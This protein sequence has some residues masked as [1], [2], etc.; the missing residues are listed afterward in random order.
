MSGAPAGQFNLSD[1]GT[2][3]LGSGRENVNALLG[4]LQDNGGLTPTH[5]PQPGSPAIDNGTSSDAPFR[6]QRSYFRAGAAPDVGA[7]EFDGIFPSTLANISTRVRVETGDNALI[8]GFIVTGDQPRRLIARAIGP[9]LGFAGTLADPQLALYNAA[10]ELLASNNNWQEAPNRQEIVDSTVAPS[11]QA[12]SAILGSLAPGAYTAIVSGVNDGTGIALVELYDLDRPSGSKLGN[13]SSRGVVQTGDD[14]MI[15]G[16]IVRGPDQQR[17]IIRA[18]GPSLPVAGALAD[19]TLEVY[20]SNGLL[21]D[22]NNDWRKGDEGGVIATTIP[23][24][25]DLESATV[26]FLSPGAYTA[27]VRGVGDT[28]GVGLVEVYALEN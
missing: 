20:D 13:I 26:L 24:T 10:G 22:N 18:I 28:T 17:V 2:C 5:M 12:E 21:R 25:N 8:G 9:S 27:I 19:P 15:G 16:F 11:H 14:V 7:V 23:P 1:D 4:P 6:D 3:R